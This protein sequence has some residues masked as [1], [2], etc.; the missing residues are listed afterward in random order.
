MLAEMHYVVLERI[1]AV[2]EIYLFW[3]TVSLVVIAAT[4]IA[5]KF[6]S[7]GKGEWK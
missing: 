3:I 5:K 1:P 4:L 2:L 7:D 6:G